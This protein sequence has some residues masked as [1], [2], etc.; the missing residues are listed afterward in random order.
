MKA[1]IVPRYGDPDV[2]E[3]VEL[4]TPKP[5][6]GQVLVRVRATLATPPDS[7]IRAADPF[8]VR[9]FSGFLR[10][11]TPVLGDMFAG[12]VQENGAGATRFAPGT[13]VFGCLSMETGAYAEYI[14]LSETGPIEE[15]PPGLGFNEAVAL[16]DGYMTAITFLRDE[17]R[18][19]TG[20][21]LLVNGASGAIGAAAIQLGRFYGADVTGVCSA[22]NT[23]LVRELGADRVIDY[24]KKDFTTDKAR[25]D[26]IFDAIGK[27]SYGKAKRALLPDGLY[28]T[29][30][31]S[32]GI[33]LTMLGQ[34]GRRGGK[35]GKLL[36]TGLRPTAIKAKD[37]AFLVELIGKGALRP[38]VD[39]V[40]DLEDMADAHRRVDTGHKVGS[41]VVAL[42]PADLIEAQ[43]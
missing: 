40:F 38:I 10:P 29:T 8:I 2:F 18:I 11:K 3:S 37:M 17:A 4:P 36:T 30:V 5:G 32:L 1:M 26:V 14:T 31:P 42:P 25:Y 20:T 7:A 28:L 23:G 41:V 6:P 22:R 34:I 13:Q 15:M 9:L 19:G 27:S 43:G 12:T 21:R 24:A 35:R 16:V 39:S 33:G